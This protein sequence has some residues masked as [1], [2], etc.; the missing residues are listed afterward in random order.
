MIERRGNMFTDYNTDDNY[1]IT[2]NA[3]IIG[4]NR[5]VMGAGVALEAKNRFN[6][7]D[8]VF[9]N[10]INQL[11]GDWPRDTYPHYG[12]LPKVYKNIGMFQTKYHWRDPSPIDL[13]KF[14]TDMLNN[15]VYK[16]PGEVFH[17]PFPGINNGRLSPGRVY[18][19]IMGL[20]D[21]IIVWRLQ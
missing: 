3:V 21:T 12:C 19:I 2:T 10:Y 1:L 14:S 18:P 11:F 9:G 15:Y 16:H 5:L 8:R 4:E 13:I 6:K 17:L 20:P 7:I